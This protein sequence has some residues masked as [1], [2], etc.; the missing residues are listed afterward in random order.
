VQIAI[1]V[2][3]EEHPVL[4]DLA[5]A[6]QAEGLKAPRIGEDGVGPGHETVQSSHLADE[7]VAGAEVEVVGVGQEDFDAEIFGEIAV[8]E[9]FDSGLRADEHE[10]R[11]FDGAVRGV[12][13]AGA[14]ARVRALGDYFEG[15]GAQVEIVA[16]R[17]GGAIAPR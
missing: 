7:L 5:K 13:E 10:D 16:R 11:G 3:L 15:N 4:G 9:A 12:Q 2:R 1:E 14:G 6:A 17:G 8:G